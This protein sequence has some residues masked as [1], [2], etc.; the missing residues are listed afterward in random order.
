MCTISKDIGLNKKIQIYLPNKESM[1]GSRCEKMNMA[2]K[3]EM[4]MNFNES[5]I[6]IC[7][8]GMTGKQGILN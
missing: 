6:G 3:C 4:S 1:S 7:K 8:K 2:T 5:I